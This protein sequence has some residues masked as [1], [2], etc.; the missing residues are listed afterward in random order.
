MTDSKHGRQPSAAN[1]R[2]VA[3]VYARKSVVKDKRDEVS[4]ERQVTLC[5]EEAERRGWAYEVYKDAEGHR[6]GGSEKHRPEWRRLKLQLA[7]ADV[8]AVIVADI[9]R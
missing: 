8:A 5:T 2:R 9:S 1:A 3:L 4:P 7:R 6:S